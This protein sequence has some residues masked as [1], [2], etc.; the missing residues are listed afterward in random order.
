MIQLNM[1]DLWY[2]LDNIGNY[3]DDDDDD[4]ILPEL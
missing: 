1:H 2:Y 4:E 3:F